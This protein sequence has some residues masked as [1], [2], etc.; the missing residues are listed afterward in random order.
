MTANNRQ[1]ENNE[2][3]RSGREVLTF[4]AEPGLKDLI[5]QKVEE[6]GYPNTS[7]MI[8][9]ALQQFFESEDNLLKI[10]G[11]ITAVVS[12]VYDHHDL[13]TLTKFL[14]LQHHSNIT[15]S[16]HLHLTNSECLEIIMLIAP[17]AEIIEFQTKLRGLKDLKYISVNLIA[18]SNNI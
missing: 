14:E 16:S 18:R 12:V 17:A 15:F 10:T 2:K 5:T 7:R 9:D 1:I 4:S 6:L 13:D 11:I 8:R 3:K